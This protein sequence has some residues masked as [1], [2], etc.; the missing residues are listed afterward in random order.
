MPMTKHRAFQA[1]TRIA[2]ILCGAAVL[3]CIVL[4][5]NAVGPHPRDSQELMAFLS[6]VLGGWAGEA[7]WRWKILR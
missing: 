3:L 6:V 7:W 2:C 5:E 1:L 4:G